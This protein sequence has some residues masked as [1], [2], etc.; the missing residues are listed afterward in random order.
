M[1]KGTEFSS[2]TSRWT[3]LTSGSSLRS[4]FL[5]SGSKNST[6]FSIENLAASS[7]ASTWRITFSSSR[8][9]SIDQRLST[10]SSWCV[11]GAFF[12]CQQ[13]YISANALTIVWYKNTPTMAIANSCVVTCK[14]VQI[15]PHVGLPLFWALI[16]FFHSVIMLVLSLLEDAAAMRWW[17]G[18]SWVCVRAFV[19]VYFPYT[20]CLTYCYG[21]HSTRFWVLQ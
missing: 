18:A 21:L 6:L 14:T 5:V 16:S 17:S 10:F 7:C 4:F 20:S 13:G 3:S 15:V 19:S 9:S 2:L 12:I 8:N 11:H 1:L